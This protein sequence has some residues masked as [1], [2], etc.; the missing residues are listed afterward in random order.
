MKPS[1]NVSRSLSGFKREI[2]G[3]RERDRQR[4]KRERDNQGE[5]GEEEKIERMKKEEL[6]KLKIYQKI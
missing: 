2:Q 6:Q 3:E 4:R 5:E 1:T